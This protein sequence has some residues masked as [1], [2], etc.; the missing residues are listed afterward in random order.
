MRMHAFQVGE[1]YLAVKG[2]PVFNPGVFDNSIRDSFLIF[3]GELETASRAY[4][5][6]A[7]L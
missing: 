2:V 5:L 1:H 7:H 4:L 3:T 6:V